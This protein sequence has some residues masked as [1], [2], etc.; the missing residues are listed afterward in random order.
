MNADAKYY[1][2][3]NS[4]AAGFKR[5][6]KPQVR[7]VPD[8]AHCASPRVTSAVVWC[9]KCGSNGRRI[10]DGAAAAAAQREH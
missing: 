6:S 10:A 5:L 9:R 7:G 8:G 3:S 4:L 2:D 1:G